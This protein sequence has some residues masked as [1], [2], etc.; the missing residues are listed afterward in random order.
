[1]PQRKP[2]NLLVRLNLFK[3]VGETAKCF[4]SLFAPNSFLEFEYEKPSS[5]VNHCWN[6]YKQSDFGQRHSN[7]LNGN[8]FEVI[9]NSL[10]IREDILP[11]Y[12][13]AKVAFVPNVE[14]D[15]I[16]YTPKAPIAL[17]LKT[18]LR[19]RYKQAD[20]EA[21]ALKYVHRNAECYLLT[22]SAEECNTVNYKIAHGEAIGLTKAI[23][24][25]TNDFDDFIKELKNNKFELAGNVNIIESSQIITKDI[26]QNGP[27]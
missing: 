21:I 1:M 9:I 16:L 7:S 24:C 13:Q 23:L 19:E 22:L 10:L 4:E 8:M 11:F 12:L 5:Y 6:L 20:L 3:R 25:T 26:L 17:S 14:F 18:S 15:N 27:Q 2:K